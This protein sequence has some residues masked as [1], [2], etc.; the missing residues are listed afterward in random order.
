MSTAE[1]LRPHRLEDIPL[2][3]EVDLR[4]L[5]PEQVVTFFET[6]VQEQDWLLHAGPVHYLI[7]E[8]RPGHDLYRTEACATAI[9]A[10]TI[11]PQALHVAIFNGRLRGTL[12]TLIEGYNK[13]LPEGEAKLPP[14]VSGF[15]SLNGKDSKIALTS[16]MY[17][18]II[19][20]GTDLTHDGVVHALPRRS[21][22]QEENQGIPHADWQSSEAVLPKAVYHVSKNIGKLLYQPPGAHPLYE[23]RA[24][25]HKEEKSQAVQLGWAA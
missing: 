12:R 2:H 25:T 23:L 9:Y 1:Y 3:G 5:P 6:G 17:E 24:F 13:T 16:Y 21:F 22:V 11:A 8:P 20:G 4:D 19:N 10:T 18:H 7:V 15:N 14:P